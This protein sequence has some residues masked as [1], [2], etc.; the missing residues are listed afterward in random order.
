VQCRFVAQRD[1]KAGTPPHT[2]F[3]LK[4]DFCP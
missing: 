3:D 4:S 1:S 2:P